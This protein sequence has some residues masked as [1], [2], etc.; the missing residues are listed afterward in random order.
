MVLGWYGSCLYLKKLGEESGLGK[1]NMFAYLAETE[2]LHP[3]KIL[4]SVAVE[5]HQID[6]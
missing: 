5:G 3:L 4:P 1:S 2:P 6:M